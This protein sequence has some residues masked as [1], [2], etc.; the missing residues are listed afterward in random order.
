MTSRSTEPAQLTMSALTFA[1]RAETPGAAAALLARAGVPVIPCVAGAKQPMTTHGFH[2]ATTDPTQIETWWRRSP[3]A[4]IGLPTGTTTGV[5]VVDVDV[6]PSGSGFGAFR[7]ARA[8]GLLTGWGMVVSTPSGGLHVYFAAGE[9]D[10]RSWQA[11]AQHV[12]FRGDGGYVV[13]PPSRVTAGGGTQPYI[14]KATAIDEARSI[15]TDALRSF[16]DPP[17]LTTRPMPTPDSGRQPD[18]L[19]AWVASRPEGSRN[20]G[21]F[22]AACEMAREGHPFRTSLELLGSAAIT[23]GLSAAEAEATIRSAHRRVTALGPE[24]G[25]RP[26]PAANRHLST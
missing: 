1:A 17:R 11:P 4:N 3:E 8:E 18:R 15:D 16:L 21:L 13:V 25:A 26:P 22:W 5:V 23:A 19:A 9:A 10:Q 12:D 7:R 14:V 2:D 20:H 6:H 24:V